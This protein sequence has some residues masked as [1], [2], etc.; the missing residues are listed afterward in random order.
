MLKKT[1]AATGILAAIGGGMITSIPAS[2]QAPAKDDHTYR[3]SSSHS[4]RSAFRQYHRNRNSNWNAEDAI[5]R[6]RLPLTSTNTLTPTVNVSP[7]AAPGVVQTP[8]V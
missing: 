7:V 8:V 3:D 5:N 1:I 2:A 6:I 4:R